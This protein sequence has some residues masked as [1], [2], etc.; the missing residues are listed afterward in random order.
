MTMKIPSLLK[1]I[2]IFFVTT[3][4]FIFFSY[5][6]YTT[7]P[8]LVE[9]KECG[10]A[11]T[12]SFKGLKYN[13]GRF[14]GLCVDDCQNRPAHFLTSQKLTNELL[15]ANVLHQNKFWTAE[16]SL[17]SLKSSEILFER[18][19]WNMNHIS[20]RFNF[21]DPILLTSVDLKENF[22]K[23]K[24]K[25]NSIVFSPEAALPVN[26]TYDLFDGFM[27]RYG[28]IYKAYSNDQYLEIA[29]QLNHKIKKLSLNLDSKESQTLLVASFL[30]AA[31]RP[32]Q[33][34]QLVFNNCATASIDLVLESKKLLRSKG[35]DV[36]DVVDPLRG[37]PADINLGTLRSLY[38]WDLISSQEKSGTGPGK[39]FHRVR[40]RVLLKDF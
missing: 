2:S 27:G 29:R 5:L 3:L 10:C 24:M 36:W 17:G 23:I 11:Q 32:L 9:S 15:I 4:M 38:W 34:Y 28:F 37:I 8:I 22:K 14:K 7:E 25:S 1:L 12:K 40:L 18:F 31:D 6:N 13:Y 19:A 20:I 21:D 30:K 35:W 16:I 26:H 39:L 33:T